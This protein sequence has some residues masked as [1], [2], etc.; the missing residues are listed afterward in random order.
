MFYD[1]AFSSICIPTFNREHHIESALKYAL[2][3]NY[4]NLEI[5]VVDNC[6]TDSTVQIC[7]QFKEKDQEFHF[8]LMI[9]ILVLVP[10]LIVVR[11]WLKVSI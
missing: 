6:S 2:S 7:Q 1:K 3:Q 4:A 10:I 8:M 5:L 9:L 11:N